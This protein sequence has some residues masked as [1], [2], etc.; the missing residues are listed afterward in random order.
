MQ[1]DFILIIITIALSAFFS[2][3]EVAIVATPQLKAEQLAQK[4]IKNANLLL[5]LKN[6]P[7]ETLI[8]ILI[9][10]NITNVAS[11]AIA[12]KIAF[13]IFNN[14]NISIIT[15]I[16]TLIILTFG[17]IIPKTFVAKNSKNIALTIAPIITA[18]SYI[19]YP[20]VKGFSAMSTAVNKI[21]GNANE[22]PLVT[23]TEIKYLIQV[24]EKTG[25]I[26]KN[27]KNIINKVFK[28]DDVS[29]AKIMTP[30]QEIFSLDWNLS[31]EHA[32]P[33]II[34][35]GF[36]R[37]PIHSESKAKIK[38]MITIQDVLG[39]IY[40]G[41]HDAKL[42]TIM[43][44]VYFVNKHKKLDETLKELQLRNYHLAIIL[45]KNKKVIG[46]VTVEDILE[47]LVGEIF[48]EEDKVDFLITQLSD[49]EWTIKG[50]T[51][52]RT[53]NKK[54]NINLPIIN[55]FKPISKFL[56]ERMD[57]TEK[58]K[59]YKYKQDNILITIKQGRAEKIHSV[60]IKKLNSLI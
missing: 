16:M 38:G 13:E 8:T 49:D 20:L 31:V 59:T 11:S 54:L 28:L 47:E 2:G 60:S 27:E 57:S 4:K 46:L 56:K 22:D 34:E 41:N 51:F 18:L 14:T 32:I 42:K 55:E 36:T 43:N 33:L 44:P 53:I 21:S 1:T 30:E 10:N 9:G 5:K 40:K 7:N 29:V 50:K 26:N 45:N 24:G 6:K 23:E 3:S 58:G 15:G 37:M 39:E 19:F 52:I 25:E 12:T 48:D 17:E 35:N